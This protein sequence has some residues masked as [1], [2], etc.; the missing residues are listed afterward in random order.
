M[1]G[2][3]VESLTEAGREPG[4]GLPR[5]HDSLLFRSDTKLWEYGNERWADK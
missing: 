5:L 1:L 3:L 4:A 2:P